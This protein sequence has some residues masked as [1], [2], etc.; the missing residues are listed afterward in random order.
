M[1]GVSGLKE[2][3]RELERLAELLEDTLPV[4]MQEILHVL[5]KDCR[6]LGVSLQ[7]F[8]LLRLLEKHGYC[9]AAEI[10]GIL[11]ITSGPVTHVTRRLIDQ[12]LIRLTRDERDRRVHRFTI[13]G[14]GEALIRRVSTRRKAL[15]RTVF[16]D[17]GTE[18][19]GEVV[20][21]IGRLGK[22]LAAASA[23]LGPIEPLAAP[24]DAAPDRES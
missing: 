18:N 17:L 1:C 15:W 6:L 9:T 23:E 16:A 22:R 2:Q 11:G 5:S 24:G 14:R 13:T 8:Y 3:E 21:Y 19:G 12:G 7:Q 4:A 20:S 10:G